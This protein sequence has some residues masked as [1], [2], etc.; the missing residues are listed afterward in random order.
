MPVV[1]AV[2]TVLAA[3]SVFGAFTGGAAARADDLVLA[4]PHPSLKENAITVQF[5]AG[6]GLGDSFTGRGVGLGYGYM[7]QGPLWLDLQMN[8]RASGCGPFRSSCGAHTGNDAELM[9]GVAWR[10]RTD[11]PVVPFLRGDAGLVYLYPD[12]AQSA[13]GLAVRGGAGMRYY[14]F[15]WLGFGVEGALSLGHG[16][17]AQAYTAGKG[18]AVVD[19]A[20]GV[21]YQFR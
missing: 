21:E 17:F 19:V 7:L 14:V 15:D 1:F 18:Y 12:G 5:L 4:G 8:V 10:F 3:A 16:Y 11:I 6:E 9:A 13:F 2:F 20:F